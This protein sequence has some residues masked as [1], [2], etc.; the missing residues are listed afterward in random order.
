MTPT[1]LNLLMNLSQAVV[2]APSLTNCWMCHPLLNPTNKHVNA[3][4][5]SGTA[6]SLTTD[7]SDTPGT[8]TLL[9]CTDALPNQILTMQKQNASL[10][11]NFLSEV[12][13]TGTSRK[14]V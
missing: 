13:A 9:I 1:L 3:V 2:T 8:P 14:G 11:I 6:I 12:G 4:P 5:L 7:V 10:N